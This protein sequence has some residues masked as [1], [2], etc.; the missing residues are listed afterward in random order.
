[1]GIDVLSSSDRNSAGDIDTL[2]MMR[3]ASEFMSD[4]LNNLLSIQKIEEGKFEL[5][6]SPFSFE[7]VILKVFAT[8]RGAVTQKNLSLS[9]KIYPNVP[10]EVIGDVHR[11]EH[12]F[13]N[14]LSNAIKFSPEGK[15][16]RLEVL[17]ESISERVD[18]TKIANTVITV[19]DAGVGISKD[20]QAKLFN[21]FVQIRPGTLQKGQ[22]SGLG[23]SFCKQIVNLHGGS[24]G[25][26]STEGYGSKFQ[27]QIPF[28]IA[29]PSAYPLHM[30]TTYNQSYQGN[31]VHEVPSTVSNSVSTSMQKANVEVDLEAPTI[32]SQ[33]ID[34]SSLKVLVVDDAEFNRKLL[35][36]LVN[37][38]GFI[39]R[40]TEDGQEAVDVI[41]ADMGFYQLMLMDNLMP[42]M[43]GSDAAKVLRRAGYPY[44]I[45]G[46]TGNVMEDDLAEFLASGADMVIAKP[47]KKQTLDLLLELIKKSGTL[48]KPHQTL[49]QKN[50]NIIW[51]DK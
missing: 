31:E 8:F 11:I 45:I 18:G 47:F 35:M 5:E 41:L 20:D 28:P 10:I 36:M 24:I 13:S 19:E 46:I 38:L 33:T 15:A 27:F 21:S 2:S 22:G 1:M 16:V 49:V 26:T 4:T 44:L 29:T 34:M 3:S 9:H 6:L 51:V 40:S 42:R 50:G 12:V 14:M 48:S 30:G 17:C 25:V 23:L 43:N 7:H 32:V 37:K 39:S